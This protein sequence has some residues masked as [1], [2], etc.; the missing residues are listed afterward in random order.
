[1]LKTTACALLPGLLAL[2]GESWQFDQPKSDEEHNATFMRELTENVREDENELHEYAAKVING[3]VPII[4]GSV[5]HAH[6]AIK[7]TAIGHRILGVTTDANSHVCFIL[8]DSSTTSNVGFVL[9]KDN[10]ELL[11]DGCEP[12]ISNHH[13]L[14]NDWWFYRSP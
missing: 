10:A 14:F 13:N 7:P 6:T 8:T 4:P 1:M 2:I 12:G 9:R 11:G 5:L 3:A